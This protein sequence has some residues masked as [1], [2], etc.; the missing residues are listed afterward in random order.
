MASFVQDLRFGFRLLVRQRGFTAVAA[1]VL[2]LGIGANTAVFSLV[3]ALVLK[4]RPGAPDAELAGVYSRDRTQADEYRGFSYPNY[5]DLRARTDLFRSLA[6][7]TF[8]LVGLGEG[9]TTRRVFIDIAT[10][11]FFDTFGVPLLH[12]RTFSTDEERPGAD[13]PVTILSYGA[14]QRM[15]G[16]PDLVGS[17]IRLNGR[18]FTV[19]GVAPRGFGGSMVLVSPDL[20]VPTGVRHDLERLRPRRVAG[21]DGGPPAP[22]ADP[23]RA[24]ASRRDDGVGAPGLGPPASRS[25]GRS[26]REQGSAL[27]MA[28]LAR[29]SVSTSPQTDRELASSRFC[30]SRCRALSSSS[31]R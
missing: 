24:P 4:P 6:A 1:L 9:E 13:I 29:M 30:S 5:V 2:T 17:Q 14:W 21:D 18:Q 8:S 7:H 20:W 23:D 19:I 10:A 26:R 12:G 28:P 11:N 15:G 27:T 3:N 22:H 25:S 31:R 16:G